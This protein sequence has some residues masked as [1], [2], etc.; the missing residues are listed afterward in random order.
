MHLDISTPRS[1]GFIK[2]SFPGSGWLV[3][4]VYGSCM[5]VFPL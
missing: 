3:G 1:C 4:H 2:Y 5:T